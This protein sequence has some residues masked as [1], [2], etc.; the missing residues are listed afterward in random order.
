[1]GLNSVSEALRSAIDNADL[2][3]VGAGFF[4]LTIAERAASDSRAKVLVLDRRGEIGGNA[5]SYREPETGIEVHKYGSHLFHTSNNHVWDYVRRFTDFND[6][7][8]TVHTIHKGKVYSLPINLGTICEFL[9]RSVSPGEAQH[10]V[11]SE[12]QSLDP[13]TATNFEDRAIALIGRPLY[14]AFIRGYTEKQWQTNPRDLPAGV[15]SR[16]PVR[17]TFNNRYFNDRWE[18][19]PL[20]GYS[21]WFERM[22]DSP[23]IDIRTGVDFFDIRDLIPTGTPVVYTGPLDE[24]FDYRAGTLTWRTLDFDITVLDVEDFQGTSVMNYAD[25]DVTHTRIHEFKHLHPERETVVGKTVIMKEFS[26]FAHQRD[27]PY[28]PV[29]SESD[30]KV[31]QQYREMAAAT[32]NVTFGGRLGSYQYLDMHMAIASALS[33][34]ERD[35]LSVLKQRRS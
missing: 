9:G 14:E 22:I 23:L 21:A 6:Y 8:H 3:V 16:L 1:M 20:N 29:N 26:R 32:S 31:L 11:R 7:R 17:Y 2:I 12:S 13:G 5:Y 27:E 19:L 25:T 10:W 4:G 33:T 15:I 35:I 30:R 24:F 34:Y 18:G 28:Y